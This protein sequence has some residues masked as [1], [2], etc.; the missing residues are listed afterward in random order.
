MELGLQVQGGEKERWLDGIIKVYEE[1]FFLTI[2][3]KSFIDLTASKW[4]EISIF[5]TKRY[6]NK[7]YFE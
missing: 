6:I 7:M 2:L 3:N 5:R 1:I 4:T